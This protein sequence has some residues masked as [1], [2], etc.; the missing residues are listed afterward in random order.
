MLAVMLVNVE[1]PGAQLRVVAF[2]KLYGDE[3]TSGQ[4]T[5]LVSVP[6]AL[7]PVASMVVVP[8]PSFNL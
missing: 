2:A 3:E 1:P 5:P 8:V 4:P 7:S 6:L